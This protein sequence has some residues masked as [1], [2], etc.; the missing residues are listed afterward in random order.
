M[1]DDDSLLSSNNFLEHDEYEYLQ[2]MTMTTNS[3]TSADPPTTIA[4]LAKL[5]TK[6]CTKMHN[7]FVLL[8]Y[9]VAALREENKRL[10]S[11][12]QVDDTPV[13]Q[14]ASSADVSTSSSSSVPVTPPPQSAAQ[15]SP[16][17]T[18]LVEPNRPEGGE[19]PCKA[20]SCKMMF[21]KDQTKH[22]DRKNHAGHL[23]SALHNVGMSQGVQNIRLN[24]RSG[25]V[26]FAPHRCQC[27]GED[28][29]RIGMRV[30]DF[31][32]E[33]LSCFECWL[34]RESDFLKRLVAGLVDGAKF[35]L[36]EVGV[37]QA[38]KRAAGD[39]SAGT[40]HRAAVDVNGA[41]QRAP[42]HS[43]DA[44][45]HGEGDFAVA[46]ASTIAQ[47]GACYLVF[48]ANQLHAVLER[49]RGDEPFHIA[50]VGRLQR[51]MSYITH[52]AA[53]QRIGKTH[54]PVAMH[55]FVDWFVIVMCDLRRTSDTGAIDVDSLRGDLMSGKVVVCSGRSDGWR[56]LRRANDMDSLA[57]PMDPS[58]FAALSVR[59]HE[60]DAETMMLA[61]GEIHKVDVKKQRNGATI[62]FAPTAPVVD[63]DFML[64]E[65]LV[66]VEQ[67]Q[68]V[69]P[70]A[71]ANG[72]EAETALVQCAAKVVAEGEAAASEALERVAMEMSTPTN[73]VDAD[74]GEK[75]GGEKAAIE[76]LV[77]EAFE[78]EKARKEKAGTRKDGIIV[79]PYQG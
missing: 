23:R 6:A 56:E 40:S 5:L 49:P 38:A 44:E 30:G 48:R 62:A 63:G 76:R 51:W 11:F 10:R 13:Q 78:R 77:R 25:G 75:E 9:E 79:K 67:W 53:G 16:S 71:S 43:H 12:F 29:A 2:N 73:D 35:A 57:L 69:R 28:H 18:V 22:K 42:Q 34:P 14:S 65:M 50:D 17:N 15:S 59:V 64:I 19:F 3:S 47:P 31:A 20:G 32:G 52:L 46:I 74:D 61:T 33:F 41:P 39:A 70:R 55:G 54:I 36:F 37:R 68:L 26:L 45:S 58:K 72:G 66:M 60:P 27:A 1:T 21:T 4:D 24:K 8:E 7:R